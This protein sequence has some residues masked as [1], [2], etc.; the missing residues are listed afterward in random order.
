MGPCIGYK[1]QTAITEINY[2]DND[3]RAVFIQTGKNTNE[4]INIF[5]NRNAIA[6]IRT[7]TFSQTIYRIMASAPFSHNYLQV[8]I[9]Y[10][11][12]LSVTRKIGTT[13]VIVS[14]SKSIY[15]Y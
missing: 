11:I 4:H 14:A 13:F 2:I 3:S 10:A 1:R 7:D 8:R 12:A 6:P 9:L 15:I 5:N